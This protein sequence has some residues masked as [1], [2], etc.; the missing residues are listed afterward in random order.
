MIKE[1]RQK[2][3][4]QQQQN[5]NEKVIYVPPPYQCNPYQYHYLINVCNSSFSVSF[6]GIP[7]TFD[8]LIQ[9]FHK[10][11]CIVL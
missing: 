10:A 1:I 2:Q 7:P 9:S 4:Q 6:A 11:A 8:N 3:Q 5:E